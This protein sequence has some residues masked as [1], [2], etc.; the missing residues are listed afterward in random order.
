MR[1]LTI[2]LTLFPLMAFGQAFTLEQCIDSAI[3]NNLLIKKNAVS[4]KIA[5]ITLKNS[6]QNLLPSINANVVHGYNWGQTIDPFTN[7]FATNQVQYDNFY[8]SSSVILFSGLQSYYSIKAN[9]LGSRQSQL[10]LVVDIRNLKMDISSAFLQVLLNQSILEISENN[11][12]KTKQQLNRIIELKT[13]NQATQFDLSE[14]EGQLSLDK[15]FVTKAKN[16]VN[17]SKLLLQQLMNIKLSEQFEIEEEFEVKN[18]INLTTIDDSIIETFPDITSINLGVEKQLMLVKSVKGR[19]YPSLLLSGSLGSGYSGNN[20]E[21]Q[22]DGTFSP[23]AFNRQLN[24]N[25]YQSAQLTLNIPIFNKNATRNQIKIAELQLQSLYLD[26]ESEY[27][28]LKQK[29]EQL[30]MDIINESEQYTALQKVQEASS[31][32][33]GNF[34]T[35]YENGDITFVQLREAQNKLFNAESNLIQSEY[36]LKFKSVLLSFYF[37]N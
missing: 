19:Y 27:N 29:I 11:L 18:Q 31:L 7:Q 13:A 20:K 6:K 28:Q 1:F 30:S 2:L 21:Y 32:N 33:Y 34:K 22:P 3:Q 26:K 14:I 24:E 17:F 37:I 8:L 15:Y 25:F 9:N 23:K 35:R 12:D 36:Q 10:A 5:D 4:I 16:D